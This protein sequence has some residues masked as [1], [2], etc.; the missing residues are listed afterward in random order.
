MLTVTTQERRNRLALR[1]R[2]TGTAPDP[3]GAARAM[4]G[5]H[6]S[7]PATVY[8]SVFARSPESNVE[9][10]EHALY[11]D[12]TLVRILGMRRTMWVI[13]V[14]NAGLVNSSS[15][16][17]LVAP[18]LKRLASMLETAAI[19]DDGMQW[20]AAISSAVIDS[21]EQRGEAT[22]REITEDVP[23]LG[24]KLTMY[25]KDGSVMGDF[26]VSTRVLFMLATEGRIVRARPLGTW[27]SSQYRW[28]TVESWLGHDMES[29][30]TNQAQER[31]VAD[32][33][34][35]FGP[36]T[37]V[38]IKWWTGWR[39]TDVRRALEAVGATEVELGA[40]QVGYLHPADLD[41]VEPAGP[42]VALLP[43]LDPTT[44]GWKERDWYLGEHAAHLFDRNG[45]AGPTVWA[46]GRVIGGWAQRRS[47]EVAVELLEEVSRE[48][49]TRVEEAAAKLQVRLGDVVVT[50]RFR[51]PLE[52]GLVG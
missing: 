10:V 27:I 5:L 6:S 12:K 26:G 13:P 28:S 2:L 29:F 17:E 14:E 50:P 45:N 33:L 23:E 36:G 32:W 30:D 1:H 41:P 49:T 4:V 48:V 52:K 35:A 51:T 18:Q 40:G 46:D 43:S 8:L 16:R 38:D 7:D 42:W 11:K 39:V 20:Y 15:T 9:D 3:A 24:T 25:K 44:M 21:L 31:L 34:M 47:G 22:A 37:E 19:T